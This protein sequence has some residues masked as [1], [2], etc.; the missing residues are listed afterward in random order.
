MNP[1]RPLCTCSRDKPAYPGPGCGGR[2]LNPAVPHGTGFLSTELLLSP[3]L[4]VCELAVTAAAVTHGH[5]SSLG[6]SVLYTSSC[7]MSASG[8]GQQG[9]AVAAVA[10]HEHTQGTRVVATGHAQHNCTPHTTHHT[11]RTTH[12]APHTTLAGNCPPA[13]CCVWCTG[14]PHR[15]W[16]RSVT[17]RTGVRTLYSASCKCRMSAAVKPGAVHL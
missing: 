10:M 1:Q 15:T 16:Q 11:P 7:S 8:A 2:G 17:S 3:I 4:A 14:H 13:V 5:P 9:V 6:S 12:H